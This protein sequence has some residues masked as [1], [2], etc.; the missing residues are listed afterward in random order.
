MTTKERDN[1]MSELMRMLAGMDPV[2]PAMA[3]IRFF[4]EIETFISKIEQIG[5]KEGF[6]EGYKEAKRKLE[7]EQGKLN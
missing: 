7:K 3:G 5:Q 4:R 1:L 2:D 6:A